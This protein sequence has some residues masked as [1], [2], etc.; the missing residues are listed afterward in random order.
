MRVVT[1]DGWFHD[2]GASFVRVDDDG[3]ASV[4]VLTQELREK[5]GKE[6]GR[7]EGG[8]EGRRER[9]VRRRGEE[10]CVWGGG[11]GRWRMTVRFDKSIVVVVVVV[12]VVV[13]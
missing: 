4:T 13:A 2:D 12:V 8:R 6:R 7:R 9:G 5:G 10:L 11:R 1:Y 3:D